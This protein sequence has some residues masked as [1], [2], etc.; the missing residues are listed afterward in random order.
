MKRRNLSA[1]NVRAHSAAVSRRGDLTREEYTFSLAFFCAHVANN[2]RAK[3]SEARREEKNYH[4]KLH[5]DIRHQTDH[6]VHCAARRRENIKRMR[7]RAEEHKKRSQKREKDLSRHAG[8]YAQFN[9]I[10]LFGDFLKI[11]FDQFV[12]AQNGNKNSSSNRFFFSSSRSFSPPNKKCF[13][14]QAR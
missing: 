9:R 2:D 6:N 11:H 4:L 13:S 12:G 3:R 5:A 7:S 14:T 10:S 1:R 8:Y